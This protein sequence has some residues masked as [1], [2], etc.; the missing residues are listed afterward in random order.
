MSLADKIVLTILASS[1]L[2]LVIGE[3]TEWMNNRL[4]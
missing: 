3:A 4:R 1:F 2:S